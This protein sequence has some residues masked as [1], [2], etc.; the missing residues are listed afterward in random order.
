M[1]FSRDRYGQEQAQYF[2][3]LGDDARRRSGISQREASIKK[4]VELGYEPLEEC[5]LL[6]MKYV[7]VYLA[8]Y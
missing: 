6:M 1:D 2:M 7:N 3:F 4:K 8:P 5:L